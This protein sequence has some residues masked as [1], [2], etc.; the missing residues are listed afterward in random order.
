MT[1]VLCDA[2]IVLKWFHSEG[3]EEVEA[4]RTIL[5]AHRAGNVS[6]SILDLTVY[7]IGNVLLRSLGWPASDVG[8]QLD[9]LRTMCGTISPT[10]EEFQLA[11]D[12]GRRDD[13][14]YYDAA[15]AAVASSRG[16]VLATADRSLVSTGHGER[17]GVLVARLGLTGTI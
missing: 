4:A 3:E 2:S 9:D 16:A 12:I 13:L 1:D 6:A 11:A 10:T 15:Y 7:E 14:T 5:A 8:G 17:P